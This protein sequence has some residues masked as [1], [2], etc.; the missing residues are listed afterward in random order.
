MASVREMIKMNGSTVATL[1]LLCCASALVLSSCVSTEELY[2]EYDALNCKFVIE[3]EVG[4]IQLIRELY[5]YTLHKWQPVVFFE[6]DS[7]ALTPAA[8]KRLKIA[9]NVLDDFSTSKLALQG[10]ADHYGAVDYNLALARRR[11]N[12]VQRWLVE[13]GVDQERISLRAMGEGLQAFSDDDDVSRANNRRVEL[14]LL[15]DQGL[16]VMQMYDLQDQ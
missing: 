15:D 2:A 12:E 14:M 6:Y 10:F 8:I 11:V 9:L 1:K 7:S 3:K 4:G 16:P 5:S 13:N